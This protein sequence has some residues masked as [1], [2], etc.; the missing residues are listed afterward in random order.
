[1]GN[2]EIFGLQFAGSLLVYALIA[3]WYV[4]P[5]LAT[6]PLSAALQPLLLH[7][8]TRILGMTLLVSAVVGPGVPRAFA[9]QVAY[10]DLI[11]AVLALVSI[12]ALRARAS[13]A[14]ALVWIFNIEGF[15]DLLNALAQGI[16]LNVASTPLGAAWYIPTYAV[17]AL[18]VTHIMMFLMLLKPRPGRKP[19]R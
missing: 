6:M 16:R 5:R 2:F 11:A 14:I 4:A 12:A 8:A 9:L 18:L 1:M 15:A 17:P 7:H 3:R 19:V 13:Y 10:G